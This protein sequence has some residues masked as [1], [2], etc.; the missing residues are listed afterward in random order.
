M[1]MNGRLMESV[2]S[3]RRKSFGRRRTCTLMITR[4]CNL[5]CGYCY[6]VNK[7][8]DAAFD[9]TFETARHL[10]RDEFSF[11]LSSPDFDEIEIDFMGG[12]PFMNFNLI[13]QVV[14]WLERDPPPVPYICFAT[15]NGTLA[16]N[17]E[18][19]LARHRDHFVLG[20]SFD[21]TNEMQCEN[22]GTTSWKMMRS[23]ELLKRLWPS[24]GLHMTVSKASLRTLASGVLY[25]QRMGFRVEVALAQGIDWSE[26]DSRIYE[27]QLEDIAMAYLET[28]RGL[29]PIGLLSRHLGGI[30]GCP[31]LR[32][33]GKYCGA[34]THMVAYDYDGR[35][36]DCHVFTPLVLGNNAKT[37]GEID[38]NQRDACEDE[39]CKSCVLKLVCPT[40]AGF[41]LRFRGHVRIRDHRWCSLVLAQFRVAALF[42]QK[43]VARLVAPSFNDLAYLK[44]AVRAHEVI[45]GV[46]GRS[47]SPFVNKGVGE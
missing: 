37:I 34:G 13:K 11:V 16:V 28:D 21:G 25:L 9:M 45:Q 14:E 31:D 22:R 41:N 27:K 19:W 47:A 23:L 18:D 29:L 10:L 6:E 36:F 4:R 40:C 1:K 8:A 43:Y 26:K 17:H 12:E 7:C 30:D 3:E 35:S 42:Q 24:Q 33:Q 44:A 15:T 32:M 2:F 46:A 5:N 38:Y 39:Y 20:G